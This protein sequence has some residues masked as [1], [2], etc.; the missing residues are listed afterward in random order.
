[1]DVDIK[2]LINKLNGPTRRALEAAAGNCVSRGHYE[3][4]VEHLLV[5]FLEDSSADVQAIL[6]HFGVSPAPMLGT[7]QHSLERIGREHGSA[8][9][10]ADPPGLAPGRLD[11][12]S[13]DYGESQVR[14]G[15]LFLILLQ[16]PDRSPTGISGYLDA[17]RRDEL[18]RDI[19]RITGS[20]EPEAPGEGERRSRGP[21]RPADET[22][23]GRFTI[24]F[25]E[26]ARNGRS[27]RSSD[28]TGRSAR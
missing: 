26:R 18:K 8:G 10:L 28:A 5:P 11:R 16:R 15:T 14:S 3:V 12:A 17:I 20:K 4:T 27:T 23:I 25:T 19:Y 9:L 2:G 24:D 7:L 6:R 22:A 1:M 13:I 21:G